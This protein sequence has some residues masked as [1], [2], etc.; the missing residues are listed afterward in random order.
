MEAIFSR[1]LSMEKYIERSQ[2]LC[3]GFFQVRKGL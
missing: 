3:M 2:D 1:R